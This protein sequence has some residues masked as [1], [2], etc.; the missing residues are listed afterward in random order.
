MYNTQIGFFIID[1]GFGSLDAENVDAVKDVLR[2]VAKQFDLF[3]VIT[4]I[5]D[6]KD[7]FDEEIHVS[8]LKNGSHIDILKH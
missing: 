1:E 8:S 6:L 3:L 2:E 5:E 7:T 4:H